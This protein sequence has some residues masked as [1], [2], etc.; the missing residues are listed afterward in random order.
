MTVALRVSRP[1][2]V[3]ADRDRARSKVLNRRRESTRV[4]W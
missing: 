1:A 2:L 3:D 4:T